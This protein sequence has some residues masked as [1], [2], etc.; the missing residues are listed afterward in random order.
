METKSIKKWYSWGGVEIAGIGTVEF[1][2]QAASSVAFVKL[3]REAQRN[4]VDTS[5]TNDFTVTVT[6]QPT[7]SCDLDNRVVALGMQYADGTT[8]GELGFDVTDPESRFRLIGMINGSMIHE[9][10]HLAY[11][12]RITDGLWQNLQTNMG[13]LAGVLMQVWNIVED[14]YIE[15]RAATQSNNTALARNLKWVEFKNDQLFSVDRLDKVAGEFDGTL[16]RALNLL[17]FFKNEKLTRRKALRSPFS[18]EVLDALATI[19]RKAAT[20]NGYNTWELTKNLWDALMNQFPQ[21]P[22]APQEQG[23]G[24]QGGEQGQGQ[25]DAGQTTDADNGQTTDQFTDDFDEGDDG[26]EMLQNLMQSFVDAELNASEKGTKP[27]VRNAK[28]GH[29]KIDNVTKF[30]NAYGSEPNINV[31]RN[32][33][34]ESTIDTKFVRELQYLNESHYTPGALHTRGSRINKSALHRIAT[35]GKIFDNWVEGEN[36]KRRVVVLLVDCSSSTRGRIF[37]NQISSAR[38]LSDEMRKARIPHMVIGYTSSWDFGVDADLYQIE[39]FMMGRKLEGTADARWGKLLHVRQG[40]TPTG[41]AL[42]H[43]VTKTLKGETGARFVINLTDGEPDY[44]EGCRKE[45]DRARRDGINVWSLSTSQSVM[46]HNDEL[47]GKEN[48]FDASNNA[49]QTL[50]AAMRKVMRG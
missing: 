20:V 9:G 18:K 33:S 44:R 4:D 2:R 23:D 40:G 5:P 22:A 1:L 45:I 3:G 39:S 37:A 38:K 15:R 21:P 47:F 42:N 31:G 27:Q 46:R 13:E 36:K 26:D 28:S 10:L 11:T 49:V 34:W 17:S 16:P 35:T 25:S 12:H 43:V 32:F 14:I 24:Q 48:N 8:F 50:T 30:E 7:A 19:R 6:N 29:C 41:P